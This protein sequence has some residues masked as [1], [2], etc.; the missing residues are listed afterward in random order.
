MGTQIGGICQKNHEKL[1]IECLK[2]PQPQQQVEKVAEAFIKVSCEYEKI[3]LDQLPPY[4]PVH[5]VYQ[6]NK[7]NKKKTD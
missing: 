4:L 7:K 5:Q 2:G 3:Q 1:H 6:V